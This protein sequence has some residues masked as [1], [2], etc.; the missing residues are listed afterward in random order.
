MNGNAL[1]LRLLDL[2]RDSWHLYARAAVDNGHIA[3]QSQGATCRIN[4]GIATTN[5]RYPFSHFR[6]GIGHPHVEQVQLPQEIGGVNDT[7]QILARD[8]QLPTLVSPHGQE[9]SIIALAQ[10]F[11][12]GTAV[13]TNGRVQ[14]N[15]HT[16]G[17]DA[18]NL[19]LKDLFGETID[20]DAHSQHATSHGQGLEDGDAIAFSD[21]VI[22]S[23]K[24]SRACPYDGHLFFF[25]P[26]R[27]LWFGSRR[28][29][30]VVGEA[31]QAAN[32]QGLIHILALALRL[33]GVVA[34]P[35]QNA[36]EGDGVADQSQGLIVLALGDE[37]EVALH[38]DVGWAGDFA[39]GRLL[40][41]HEDI[42]H[43][44]GEGTVNG[45]VGTQSHLESA[46]H[47]HG[48]DGSALAAGGAFR[49]IYVTRVLSDPDLE[50]AHITLNVHHLTV[51]Q[52]LNPGMSTDIHHLGP[53]NSGGTVQSGEGLI[54]LG[55]L[56]AD[57]R[58]PLHQIDLVSGIGDV[59]GGLD[60]SDASAY[61]Q[62]RR[63]D[64]HLTRIQGFVEGH[65]VHCGRHQLPCLAG[66]L[67]SIIVYPGALFADV[68]HLEEVGVHARPL[69]SAAKGRL[70]H[71]GG[72][73]CHHDPIQP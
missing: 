73:G 35:P 63:R 43:R 65:T 8:A 47:F 68:G 15:L 17:F 19:V 72:A 71:A 48:A 5:D 66:R 56:A 21:Q 42:G 41:N 24:T 60:A 36:G 28:N 18:L 10:V 29:S 31:L 22:G 64:L 67:L 39:R 45:L 14:L 61:N 59:Q 52:E 30:G 20:R 44:L 49:F 4:G 6:G 32:R 69:H 53:Q 33:A 11:Q 57:G 3:S 51:G 54:Q 37:G 58:F 40:V 26:F 46:G 70:V 50:V 38:P 16:Q 55:H 2:A 62:S 34:D 23:G 12:A 1:F 25:R 7:L 27:G 13:P 9:D